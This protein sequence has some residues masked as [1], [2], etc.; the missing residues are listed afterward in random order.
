MSRSREASARHGAVDFAEP[1]AESRPGRRAT[2]S[3][4]SPSSESQNGIERIS[5]RRCLRLSG[6]GSA[7]GTT[8]AYFGSDRK[9]CKAAVRA[10][11]PW[12][13]PVE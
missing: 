12:K 2:V 5:Y 10:R 7:A 8:A 1:S 4:K 11:T 13:S 6:E 3:E 9:E